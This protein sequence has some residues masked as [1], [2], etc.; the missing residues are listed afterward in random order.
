VLT[1]G[2]VSGGSTIPPDFLLEVQKGNVDK[3]SMMFKFGANPDVDTTTDPEDVWN[4]GGLLVWQT[5]A[6]PISI[7]SNSDD[8]DGTPPTNT[9]AHKV[10]FQGLDD[11]FVLDE[12][13][14]TLNGT[15]PVVTTK[16]FRRGY[17]MFVT[18]VG[19]YHRTNVGSIVATYSI[20]GDVAAAIGPNAGQSEMS[21][22]TIPA[23]TK[24]Y[25]LY[26]HLV[27]QTTKTANIVMCQYPNADAIV[28]P[29]PSG[30]RRVVEGFIGVE[31]QVQLDPPAPLV[32]EAKTDIWFRVDEVSASNT[33]VAV[34]YQLLLVEN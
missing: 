16:S 23:D 31:G 12:E 7:V 6:Q 15:A 8:D 34:D 3:H 18:Q 9:G 14:V 21:H 25:L 17:R 13:E 22:F 29:F 33:A 28:S 30:S 26:A 11:N 1:G 4:V 32:F 10:L 2:P 5:A 24:G 19:T 20:T 27:I